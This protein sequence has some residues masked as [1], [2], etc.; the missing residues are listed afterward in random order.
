MSLKIKL[1]HRIIAMVLAFTFV[2]PIIPLKYID[3]EFRNESREI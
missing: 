2:L 3:A 1:Y